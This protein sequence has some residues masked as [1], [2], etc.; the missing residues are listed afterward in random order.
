[1]LALYRCGRQAEALEAYREARHTLVEQVGVEPSPELRRLHE[2]ILR[3]DAS[4]ELDASAPELPRELDTASSPPV[5]GR[6]TEI[7]SLRAH[8]QRARR[9]DGALVTLVGAHGMGKTRLAAEIADAAYGEGATVL[10]A[11][12]AGAP[13]PALA[14]IATARAPGRPTL[15][16]VDDADRAGAEVRA[17]MARLGGELHEHASLVL[18]TG[19]D[20]AAL[21][22]LRPGASL[23]LAPLDAASVRAIAVLYA[24]AGAAADVPVE[25]LLES[26]QG[27]PRQ[28]HAVASEWARREAARRVDAVAGRAA[29]GR[30]QAT[31]LEAE[32]AGSVV[33]LQSTHERAGSSSPRTARRRVVCPFKG[34]AGFDAE[35]SEYFFGREQLVAELVARLVGAPLLAIVGP[36]GSGKSS[37]LRAGLLPALAGGV[38]PRSDGWAQVLI[39]PGERPTRELH[40][41]T[42]GLRQDRRAVLAVDQFEEIFTA[43]GDERERD[44]FV[45]AIVRAAQDPRG[46]SVVVLA[47]RADFYARCAAYPELA[48]LLGANHVLVGPMSRDELRRAITRPAERVGLRVEADLED[49]VVADVDGQPGAL[50]LLSTALLELWQH[51]RAGRLQLAAYRGTGG[52]HGAV[53]RLAEDAFR[54]LEPAE[55]EIARKVLPRLAG[56]G[57]DGAIVRRRVPLADLGAQRSESVARVLDVLTDRRLL[58]ISAGTVEVAHEALLREWPRL[59]G[60]LEEDAEGRRLHRHLAHAA[61]DWDQRGRDR[62]ELYRGARLASALEWRTEHE[63]ELDAAEHQFLDASR[64]ASGRARRR[65]QLAFAGV[66][67]LLVVATV[68]GPAGAGRARPCPRTGPSRR[69]SAARCPGAERG[70]AGS[71]AAA[72]APGRRPRRHACHARQPAGRPPA[73]PGGH[74]RHARRRRRTERRRPAP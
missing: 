25:T 43:C 4:L 58:T 41:A 18:A 55:Q 67:A 12:G 11:T 9:R 40:R 22:G 59:R 23:A 2:A 34:L 72:G 17:A 35:D 27:V 56:E 68:R 47:L 8:W 29:A 74:R 7:A 49:A 39:R 73:Q 10:Y 65:I 31:A 63:P 61:R 48:R 6:D 24:P 16:V 45:A 32:L 46:G 37:A 38:L 60:W 21:A 1:M 13:E 33:A 28:V 51:R 66:V 57:E 62:G 36:S 64:A 50:P 20:A 52:V 44:A 19:Q 3:Q 53:A 30:A 42:S 69:R 15:L 54:R 71:V 70:H 5:A 26:S 14:A